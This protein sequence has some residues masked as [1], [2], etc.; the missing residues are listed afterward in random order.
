MPEHFQILEGF[1]DIG[2]G[3][4]RA[5]LSFQ[6]GKQVQFSMEDIQKISKVQSVIRG[7]RLRNST[8]G[9]LD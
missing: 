2:C 9:M 4:C 1:T 7:K 3:W 5:Q 8:A 6:A